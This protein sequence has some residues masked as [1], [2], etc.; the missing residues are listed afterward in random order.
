MYKNCQSCGGAVF[1]PTDYGTE[2]NGDL[3]ADF[4]SNCYRDGR[5][6]YDSYGDDS[7]RLPYP[8]MYNGFMGYMGM[9]SFWH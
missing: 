6:R 7:Y 9:G 4:C 1:K 3:N 8:G 2:L 5:F